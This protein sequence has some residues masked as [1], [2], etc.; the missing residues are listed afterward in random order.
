MVGSA[1][2]VVEVILIISPES[3]T[4]TP[5]VCVV[6]TDVTGEVNI[7]RGVVVVISVMLVVVT[8]V[9]VVVVGGV[10]VSS[11]GSVTE[12]FV[13]E[14]VAEVVTDAFCVE[15]RADVVVSGG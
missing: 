2:A 6:T 15:V 13:T 14:A 9:V 12:E 10:V 4:V 1:A 8:T 3:F 11:A 7:E 5:A